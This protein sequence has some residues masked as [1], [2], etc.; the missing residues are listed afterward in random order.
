MQLATNM[1]AIFAER[2]VFRDMGSSFRGDQ[3]GLDAGEIAIVAV[4]I[5]AMVATF[6]L[7]SKWANWRERRGSYHDPVYLFRRLCQIHGLRRKDRRLLT[8]LAQRHRLESTA[9]VFLRPDLFD[10]IGPLAEAATLASLG[11]RLFG[12]ASRG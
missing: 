10:S 6:W 5:V 8:Q 2:D 12:G 11:R 7:L 3:K 1:A 4:S 9:A